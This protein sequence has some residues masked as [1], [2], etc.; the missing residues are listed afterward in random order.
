MKIK[1]QRQGDDLLKN[2][3]ADAKS[4][5]KYAVENAKAQLREAFTPH[6]QSIISR[7]LAEEE[8]EDE[9]MDENDEMPDEET[10]VE[11]GDEMPDDE[12]IDEDSHEDE[13]PVEEGDEEEY[14]MEEAAEDSGEEIPMEEGEDEE[15]SDDVM[16]I[17][18]QLEEEANSSDIGSGDNKQ[19]SPASSKANTTMKKEKLV[20]LVKEEEDG[21]EI[22]VEE[23]EDAPADETPV[24]ES[25][26]DID[27]EEILNSLREEEELED[28]PVAE[29]E[30][31]GGEETAELEERL[32][33][34]YRVIGFMRTKLNEVNLINSKLLFSTKLFNSYP[35]S[36][37]QKVTVIE[38]FDRATTLREV[39]IVYTTLAESF[40]TAKRTV[41]KVP[42][43]TKLKESYA[44]KPTNT[45]RPAKKILNE[46]NNVVERM[47]KLAGIV[48]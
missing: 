24:E 21:E 45:T 29:N 7:R 13:T 26:D 4:I 18:R 12:S 35:L 34:A 16:E 47:K 11:E 14:S 40:R 46:S 15:P 42:A 28:E 17:I 5:Q 38:N 6:V 3:I 30:D 19:P 43:N 20:Q 23:N 31:G 1:S 25:E 39:K 37:S 36:E 9:T 48:K 22:P 41:T 44:S 2:A 10:P 33:E 32:R 8:M 27:L